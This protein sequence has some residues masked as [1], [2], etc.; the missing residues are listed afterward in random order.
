MFII[1][2]KNGKQMYWKSTMLSYV[3]TDST[4]NAKSFETHELAQ[5]GIEENKHLSPENWEVVEIETI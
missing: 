4:A 2:L 1:K 3:V 5:K